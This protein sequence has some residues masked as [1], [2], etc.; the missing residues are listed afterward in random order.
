MIIGGNRR[1]KRWMAPI[2]GPIVGALFVGLHGLTEINN[3]AAPPLWQ[4]FAA[5]AGIGLVAGVIVLFLR[6]K[7]PAPASRDTGG[8]IAPAPVAAPAPRRGAGAPIDCPSE[9]IAGT[10]VLVATLDGDSVNA[11]LRLADAA[12]YRLSYPHVTEMEFLSEKALLSALA[13]GDYHVAHLFLA[14]DG[15]GGFSGV[16]AERFLQACVDGQ[17]KLVFIANANPSDHCLKL[18]G[19]FT[20]RYIRGHFNLI[21]LPTRDEQAFRLHL[22]ASCA[23]MAAGESVVEGLRLAGPRPGEPMTPEWMIYPGL[24]QAVLKR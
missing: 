11:P 15:A 20:P 8:V 7:S 6:D 1:F 13:S 12:A 23:R 10:R 5:G 24:P 19:E 21:T 22:A 14:L 3:P 18:F 4:L 2:V 17:L 16:S 9:L